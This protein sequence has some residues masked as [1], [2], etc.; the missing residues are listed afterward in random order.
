M[1]RA[2]LYKNFF[3]KSTSF[4]AGFYA[5]HEYAIYLIVY[6]HHDSEKDLRKSHF[7]QFSYDFLWFYHE[8]FILR[9]VLKSLASVLPFREIYQKMQNFMGFHILHSIFW[10]SCSQGKKYCKY[11]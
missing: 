3:L 6:N 10:D 9:P 4:D 11:W 1:S 2:I 8:I 7:F 5:N